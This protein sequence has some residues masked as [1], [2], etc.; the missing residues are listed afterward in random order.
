MSEITITVGPRSYPFV[1]GDGEEEHIR[2]L[3]AMIDEK[4]QQLGNARG[5]QEA[6]NMLFA[7]LFLADELAEMRKL[8]DRSSLNVERE[9]TRSEGKKDELRAQIETLTK[10]EARARDEVVSLKQE[11][12]LMREAA[13]HQHDLFGAPSVSDEMIER[14]EA[15]AARA[16]ETATALEAHG[17]A[18]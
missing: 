7:A 2:K 5:P 17:S 8:A 6:Q 13:S 16:E 11:L 9:E 10:A 3:A 15:L 14:L 4:Y 18:S 12:A 1:C